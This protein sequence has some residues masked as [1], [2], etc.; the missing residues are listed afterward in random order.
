MDPTQTAR[1]PLS[2]SLEASKSTPEKK[3]DSVT[4]PPKINY[5]RP[6]DHV[7]DE[8]GSQSEQN[9][10]SAT[11]QDIFFACSGIQSTPFKIQKPSSTNPPLDT[12][13][14]QHVGSHPLDAKKST[15]NTTISPKKSPH[16]ADDIGITTPKLA[17]NKMSVSGFTMDDTDAIDQYSAPQIIDCDLS[18]FEFKEKQSRDCLIG[19]S[20]EAKA[21]AST[22]K[23]TEPEVTAIRAYTKNYYLLINYQLRNLPDPNVNIY[24][25]AALKKSGVNPD[26]ADLIANL[27]NGLKKLPPAQLDGQTVRGHGRDANLPEEELEKYKEGSTISP[28][29]CIS[30]TSSLAQMVENSWWNKNP[31]AI[32]IH[33]VPNGN[34]RDIAVFSPYGHES[35]ILFLP[36]TRFKVEYRK[37]NVTIGGGVGIDLNPQAIKDQYDE[38]TKK[39][40]ADKYNDPSGQKYKKTIISLRELPSDFKPEAPAKPSNSPPQEKPKPE[41]EKEKGRFKKSIKNF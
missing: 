2:S 8:V 39:D 37:D 18:S 13:A 24:D 12:K 40:W 15:E 25:A 22:H 38:K 23:L 35:E 32:I 21:L 10:K 9:I 7:N 17:Q 1:V 36:N 4:R 27:V 33:Q 30:T 34:G 16:S 19:I 5:S 26:M 6:A 20:D 3:S 14:S 29:M 41:K 11:P 31:Q 28:S